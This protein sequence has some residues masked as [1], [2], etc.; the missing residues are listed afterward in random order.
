MHILQ[1]FEQSCEKS[2]AV[3][4]CPLSKLHREISSGT[5][6]FE[7]Y[8]D[9]ERLRLRSETPS[10]FNWAKLRPQAEIEL[11]GNEKHINQLHYAALSLDGRGL[12]GYGECTVQF[13]EAM[14]SHR[15]TCFEGN[16]A[17]LFAEKQDFNGFLRSSWQ[18][19]GRLCVAKIGGKLDNSMSAHDFPGIL[20]KKGPSQTEDEFV[21]IHI[22]GTITA[23]TFQSVEIAISKNSN[24]HRTLW[25]AVKEKLDK[26]GIE[27]CER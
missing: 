4:N 8:Y 6:V 18:D 2:H 16:S 7:T 10:T 26:N 25:K 21:E 9:L 23:Q 11:L 5:D 13:N 24:R 17:L 22:F 27:N 14:I 19:R 3:F 20:L 12:D 1:E 15:A